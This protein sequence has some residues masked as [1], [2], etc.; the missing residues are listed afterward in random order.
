MLDRYRVTS[1]SCLLVAPVAF[2][3]CCLVLVGA[4]SAFTVNGSPIPVG[5]VPTGLALD[6]S[7]TRLVVVNANPFSSPRR[8][9]L[10]VIN[11]QTGQP[12]RTD[13]PLGVGSTERVAVTSDG[14]RAYVAVADRVDAVDLQTGLVTPIPTGTFAPGDSSA[15]VITPDNRRAYVTH[16]T[17]DTVAVIDI[18]QGSATYHQ[19]LA[20]IPLGGGFNTVQPFGAAV[21]PNGNELYVASGPTRTVYA[22]ATSNNSIVATIPISGVG[23]GHPGV[24]STLTISADGTA[25]YV[26]FETLLAVVST[27]TH[28]QQGEPL[29]PYPT[30]APAG[31]SIVDLLPSGQSNTLLTV[32]SNPTAILAEVSANGPAAVLDEIAIAAPTALVHRPTSSAPVYVLGSG[33][34]GVV[35]SFFL[36]AQSSACET[37][38]PF[39]WPTASGASQV[40]QDY[41]E[42][43]GSD[44]SRRKHKVCNPTTGKCENV[45]EPHHHTGMDLASPVPVSEPDR[46]QQVFAVGDGEVVAAC[47]NGVPGGCAG[48]GFSP[49]NH[50]LQGV[51]ILKHS[52]AGSGISYSLYGH[53]GTVQPFQPGDCIEQGTLV[54]K[55]GGLPDGHLHFEVKSAPVLSN[56]EV[57]SGTCIDP[58]TKNPSNV[59]F[60][61]T[62]VNP[63]T[64][65]YYDP[66]EYL[67]LLDKSGFPKTVVLSDNKDKKTNKKINVRI[68]PGAFGG[69]YP[70]IGKAEEGSYTAVSKVSGATADP[71]CFNGWYQIRR[72]DNSCSVPGHCFTN[73]EGTKDSVPEAWVCGDFVK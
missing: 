63:T 37:T 26:T 11:P 14:L 23:A 8:G 65:G 6:A 51:V 1:P 46:S 59:C 55:T 30:A 50:D 58:G 39:G 68:G 62:L 70:A 4:A 17:S 56:P 52:V 53:L 31:G 25:A 29:G 20:T 7:G 12:I 71:S 67:H 2:L 57:V 42:F 15:V 27:Q 66:V 3:L 43:N 16:R 49:S 40:S 24:Y 22:I 28:S 32:F 61:Y 60:G 35:Y 45:V 18:A 38:L 54:G 48:S 19:R 21:T 44:A 64:R 13:I 10:S 73:N 41:A 34:P 9:S 72:S 36:G 33:D 47:P 5:S 69:A